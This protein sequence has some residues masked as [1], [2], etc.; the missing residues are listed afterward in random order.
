M[1]VMSNKIISNLTQKARLDNDEEKYNGVWERQT[2]VP[3]I[4]TQSQMR[5]KIPHNPK[6]PRSN[7]DGRSGKNS[8][9]GL[10]KSV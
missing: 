10:V 1:R 6:R 2:R 9:N 8:S 3:A 4:M 7:R 5:V